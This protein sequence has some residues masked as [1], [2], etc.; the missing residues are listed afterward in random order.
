MSLLPIRILAQSD[1]DEHLYLDVHHLGPGKVTAAAVAEAHAKDLAVQRK[2]GVHF[3]KYWVDEAGGTS[4]AF[5]LL[6]T[7]NLSERPMEKHMVCSRIR[8]IR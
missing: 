3:L 2:Y 8:Y 4:I 1:K 7:P 6:L 5:L